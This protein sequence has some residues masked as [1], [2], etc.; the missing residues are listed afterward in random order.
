MLPSPW[1][2]WCEGKRF[3][4]S[5]SEDSVLV[6]LGYNNIGWLGGFEQDNPTCGR[7]CVCRFRPHGVTRSLVKKKTVTGE[8]FIRADSDVLVL[9]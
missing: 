2:V 8:N 4:E 1:A 6:Q 7:I 3:R 9:P 5:F